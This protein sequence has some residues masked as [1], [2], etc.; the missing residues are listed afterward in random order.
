M[1]INEEWMTGNRYLKIE[2]EKVGKE[3]GLGR[4]YR[5]NWQATMTY[6]FNIISIYINFTAFTQKVKLQLSVPYESILNQFKQTDSINQTNAI[7]SI[8]PN[9]QHNN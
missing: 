4:I 1:N 6:S 7:T 3:L 5:K 2:S 9:F 8:H